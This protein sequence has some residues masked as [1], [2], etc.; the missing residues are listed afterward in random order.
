MT[1]ERVSLIVVHGSPIGGLV[2]VHPMPGVR[3]LLNVPLVT[4]SFQPRPKSPSVL[5]RLS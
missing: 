1:C 3:L 4:S 2:I 5:S